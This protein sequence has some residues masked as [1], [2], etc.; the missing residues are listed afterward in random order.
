MTVKIGFS[1]PKKSKAFASLIMWAYGTPFSHVYVRFRSESY[2][3]DLIY[4]ASSVMVN[5]MGLEVFEEDNLI[6]QEFEIEIPD[7]KRIPLMQFMIDNAGRPYS[8]KQVLGL[9]F[10]RLCEMVGIKTSNPVHSQDYVC[11]ILADHIIDS[12]GT[13]KSPE[14]PTNMDPLDVWNFLNKKS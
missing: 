7:E 9:G 13:E 2:D 12:F 1:R 6:V 3:R 14:D 5:F 10:V 4:Q 11:S 8:L